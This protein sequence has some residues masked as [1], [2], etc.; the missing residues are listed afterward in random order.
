MC[1]GSYTLKF[2]TCFKE[3]TQ[4]ET[5]KVIWKLNFL[6]VI[7]FDIPPRIVKRETRF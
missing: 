2:L 7:Q 1:L 6:P 4:R 5:E 3:R